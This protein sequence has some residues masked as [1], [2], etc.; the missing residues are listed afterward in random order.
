MTRVG[1][2]A[3]RPGP[4]A[5]PPAARG[6]GAGT[7]PGRGGGPRREPG[8]APAQASTPAGARYLAE[9]ERPWVSLALVSPLILLYECYA[10][11]LLGGPAATSSLRGHGHITAFVLIDELFALFGATG[12]HL[13]AVAVV[14]MLACAHL[15][16]RDPWRVRPRTV[17]GMAAES[18]FWAAPLIVLG[19]A[20]ARLFPLGVPPHIKQTIVLC[21][22]A[23]LYEEMLFRL[24]GA[25]A[26]ILILHQGFGWRMRV[27]QPVVILG[28][29]LLFSLYHYLGPTEVFAW[30]SFAFRAAAGCYL[31]LVY[32]LR[33]FGIT[34]FSHAAYDVFAVALSAG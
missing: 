27:V 13:P 32:A 5:K 34:A 29:G 16:R 28:L 8:R 15:M 19:G 26:L 12:R 24:I 3:P 31:G 7:R 30:R 22:G 25:S 2:Q 4:A 17:A 11:G 14:G 33:G 9:S 10:S 23:G 18:L 6:A 1:R 20:L 21:A